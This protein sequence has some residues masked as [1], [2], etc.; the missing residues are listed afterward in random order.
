MIKIAISGKANTGKNTVSKILLDLIAEKISHHGNT[1]KIIAFANPIK[2]I[3]LKMFPNIPKKH[4][5]GSSKYRS[6]IIPGASKNGSPLTI[7]QLLMDIGKHGR[8][9]DSEL[10]VKRFDDRFNT[11]KN[12]DVRIIIAPDIRFRNEFSYLK[13]NGFYQIRL[14][15]NNFTNINDIS[16]TAQDELANNEF[17]YVLVNNNT[18]TDLKMEIENNIVPNINDD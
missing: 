14:L 15:R 8:Q 7:R 18:L 17:N 12:S 3:A 13:M 6:E 10:W 9:Y 4:L 5:F 1:Q 11:A 2:E 16:E